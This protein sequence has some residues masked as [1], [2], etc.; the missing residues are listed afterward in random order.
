MVGR[1]DW[2]G[3]FDER[4]TIFTDVEEVEGGAGADHFFLRDGLRT[5]VACGAGRDR[6]DA[7]PRDSVDVDCERGTVAPQLGGAR[8]TIPTLTFPF[9]SSR[10]RGRGEVRVLPLIPL[11]GA[12]VLL[13]VSCPL[14][15]GLLDLD[16]P[17]C[18]GRVRFARGGTLMGV[19]RIRV[20]RGQTK[21]LHLPLSSSRAL[22]RRAGG[23]AITATA[24]PDRGA[25][26]RVLRFT[27]RG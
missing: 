16:G 3:G 19:Q 5:A 13:R 27:V 22:A 21:T 26:Q 8:L 9:T 14:G 11:H 18:S 1:L 17:G 4:D 2:S 24:L 10:D 12:T 15:V 7:D 20:A 25:V 6:V 23:L